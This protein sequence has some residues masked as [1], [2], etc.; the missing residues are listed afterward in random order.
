MHGT[1]VQTSEPDGAEPLVVEPSGRET[2]PD[3][4]PLALVVLNASHGSLALGRHESQLELSADDLAEQVRPLIEAVLKG[5]YEESVKLSDD[6]VLLEAKGLF[7]LD[8][9]GARYEFVTCRPPNGT[10]STTK[11][12]VA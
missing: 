3:V 9:A 2:R 11:D 4:C 6:N 7:C 10:A 12:R 1:V 5:R 8:D